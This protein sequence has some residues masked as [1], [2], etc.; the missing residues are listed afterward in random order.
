MRLGASGR[1]WARV[2][3]DYEPLDR[4]RGRQKIDFSS[5]RAGCFLKIEFCRAD[6][7]HQRQQIRK[8]I[9]SQ[10]GSLSSDERWDTTDLSWQIQ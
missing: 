3:C 7:L 8:H 6:Y 9:S 1:V 10:I 5:R 2:G 4:K